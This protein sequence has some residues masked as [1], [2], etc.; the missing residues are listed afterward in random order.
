MCGVD[1]VPQP[2]R[3]TLA[4]GV[5][6][7]RTGDVAH[8]RTIGL[9]QSGLTLTGRLDADILDLMDVPG[10][11]HLPGPAQAGGCSTSVS[12]AAAMLRVVPGLEWC[13]S[14]MASPVPTGES[15][16]QPA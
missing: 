8:P 7:V 14:T 13:C 2:H 3:A 4:D 6:A 16:A 11:R 1:A 5:L 10:A 12:I 9:G 15:L